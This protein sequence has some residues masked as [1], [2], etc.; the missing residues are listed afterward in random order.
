VPWALERLA[1]FIPLFKLAYIQ[2][3]TSGE[4]I[5]YLPKYTPQ[6]QVPPYHSTLQ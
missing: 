6:V 3:S 4:E 1:T 2:I 5:P